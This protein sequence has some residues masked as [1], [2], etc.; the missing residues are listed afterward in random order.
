MSLRGNQENMHRNNSSYDMNGMDAGEGAFG[1][2]RA[3]GRGVGRGA[4]SGARAARTALWSDQPACLPLDAHAHGPA[5]RRK[6]WSLGL[7]N[8][9]PAGWAGRQRQRRIVALL[10][11]GRQQQQ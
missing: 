5:A 3:A 2:R 1:A 9:E 11:R 8:F 4:G 7:E 6:E 10:G